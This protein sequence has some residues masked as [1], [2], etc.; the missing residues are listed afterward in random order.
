MFKSI[1]KGVIL[2]VLVMTSIVL[3]YKIWNFRPNLANVETSI[4]KTNTA[5]SPKNVDNINSVFL[6]Y[7]IVSYSNDRIYGTTDKDMLLEYIKRISGLKVTDLSGNNQGISF[8]S[9]GLRDNFVIFDYAGDLPIAMYQTDILDNVVKGDTNNSFKRIIIDSYTKPNLV[10]YMITS[11]YKM[12][13]IETNGS[14]KSFNKLVKSTRRKMDSYT[15]IITN[16]K[17]TD[18]LTSI[19]V[20]EAP[21]HTQAYSYLADNINVD[22]INK[23]VL[24]DKNSII[25]R[26]DNNQSKTY[27]SNTGI[28]K[29]INN[30]LYKFNNLSEVD[31]DKPNPMN[32]L[33]NS[34]NFI[35]EHRGFTDDYRYFGVKQSDRAI[36][37]QMFY[38]G[39][40]VFN[41]KKLSEIDIIWGDKSVYEYKRGL[42]TTSVAVPTKQKVKQLPTAE[43][44]RF[45]LASNKHYQFE[46]VSNMM[47]GYNMTRSDEETIQSTLSFK[48]AWFIKYNNEWKEY[49]NGRL[50]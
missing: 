49:D 17:T 2:F 41:E 3:T 6:P 15:G 37:Y 36:N 25:E 1:L 14:S 39:Y 5:L 24:G 10:M 35:S 33:I 47:I 22:D 30:E 32:N 46:R 9:K 18:E 34:F 50:K 4:T 20:P 21:T 40:P 44:V 12:F 23:A 11:D 43:E 8:M 48:P 16:E 31:H 38:K 7:Q 19:Y 29:M 26:S 28:V 27:N 13:E 45:A 42:Y